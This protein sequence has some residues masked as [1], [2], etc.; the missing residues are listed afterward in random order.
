MWDQL[1]IYTYDGNNPKYFWRRNEWFLDLDSIFQNNDEGWYL[2]VTPSALI[3][4][5]ENNI[6]I[7]HL[8]LVQ[9]CW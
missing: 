5:S 8:K 2:I 3:W 4:H 9:T 7:K 1:G 6:D